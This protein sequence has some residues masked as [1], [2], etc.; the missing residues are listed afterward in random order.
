LNNYNNIQNIFNNDIHKIAG[1]GAMKREMLIKTLEKITE[2][3]GGKLYI[4]AVHGGAEIKAAGKPRIVAV[5]SA[6]GKGAAHK[7]KK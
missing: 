1:V 3:K 7:L 2:F 6:T 5:Y 4:K